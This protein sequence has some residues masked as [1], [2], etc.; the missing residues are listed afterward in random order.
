MKGFKSLTLPSSSNKNM[1]NHTA[2]ENNVDS[3]CFKKN[4]K[5]KR[6]ILPK[7]A[8]NVMKKWLFQHIV[9]RLLNKFDYLNF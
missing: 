4:S 7:N 1:N 9:V 6:G 2:N 8:T 3:Y 5:T